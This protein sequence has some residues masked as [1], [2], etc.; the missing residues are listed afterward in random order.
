[1][2]SFVCVCVVNKE[3]RRQ[4]NG[5]LFVLVSFLLVSFLFDNSSNSA[6][7]CGCVGVSVICVIVVV[8]VRDGQ[9]TQ[10]ATKRRMPHRPSVTDVEEI[11]FYLFICS[12]FVFRPP[13]CFRLVNTPVRAGNLLFSLSYS[14]LCLLFTFTFCSRKKTAFGFFVCLFLPP[15]SSRPT[16]NQYLNY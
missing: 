10:R 15:S 6:C 9:L 8:L 2:I 14:D 3:T 5:V 7:V 4:R 13:F 11:F 16:S 12:S 1:M